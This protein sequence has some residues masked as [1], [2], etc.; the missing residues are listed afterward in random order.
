MQV[1]EEERLV[2]GTG[3]ARGASATISPDAWNV[4]SA[5]RN[6]RWIGSVKDVILRISPSVCGVSPVT[7]LKTLQLT[8]PELLLELLPGQPML[9]PMMIHTMTTLLQLELLVTENTLP[10][11]FLPVI[12]RGLLLETFLLPETTLET[13][14]HLQ[15][16]EITHL[17][18][19]ATLLPDLHQQQQEHQLMMS[20]CASSVERQTTLTGRGVS[21]ALALD[22]DQPGVR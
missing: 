10:V 20:G 9:I 22:P 7:S 3:L 14:L 8:Q 13:T 11:T 17:L 18:Q 21:P 15:G 12:T 4:S 5:K 1:A 2:R 16:A 6:G 19:P